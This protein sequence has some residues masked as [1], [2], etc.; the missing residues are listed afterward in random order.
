VDKAE[1]LKGLQHAASPQLIQRTLEFALTPDVRLQDV[2]PLVAGGWAAMPGGGGSAASAP[3][4]TFDRATAA[5]LPA[6]SARAG[7]RPIG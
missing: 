6:T 4:F 1:L 5:C 2:G 3:A 7:A